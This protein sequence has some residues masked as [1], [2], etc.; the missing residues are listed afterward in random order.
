MGGT[1]LFHATFEF[2]RTLPSKVGIVLEHHDA[3]SAA[4]AKL[5]REPVGTPKHTTIEFDLSTSFLTVRRDHSHF[6]LAL[7]A[8]LTQGL[9]A[10]YAEAQAVPFDA[11]PDGGPLMLY[12]HDAGDWEKLELK[13]L[14]DRSLLQVFANGRQSLTTRIYP[15]TNN[16]SL[17]AFVD[18]APAHAAGQV[19]GHIPKTVHV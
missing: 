2:C 10:S 4:P 8:E 5:R 3:G 13:V 19:W 15:A 16:H 7:P 17:T 18:G 12:E 9:N 6:S 11:T 1:V 14:L